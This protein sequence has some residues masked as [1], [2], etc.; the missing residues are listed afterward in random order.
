MSVNEF[1]LDDRYFGQQ[2]KIIC[3]GIDQYTPDELHRALSKLI[4]ILPVNTRNEW[5]STETVNAINRLRV[6]SVKHCPRDHYDWKELLLLLK[7]LDTLPISPK[8][9]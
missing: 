3:N 6:I 7:I 1:G 5:T 8:G 4:N 2:L 9:E